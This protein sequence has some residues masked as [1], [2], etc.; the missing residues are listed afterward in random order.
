MVEVFLK[1][2]LELKPRTYDFLIGEC[3]IAHVFVK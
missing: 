2:V 1:D 3:L